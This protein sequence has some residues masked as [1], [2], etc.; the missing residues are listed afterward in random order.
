MNAIEQEVTELLRAKATGAPVRIEPPAEVLRHTRVR[1]VRNAIG[2]TAIAAGLVAGAIFGV[3]SIVGRQTIEPTAPIPWVDRPAVTGAGSPS[4]RSS[5]VTLR[6]G[7]SPT[8]YMRFVASTAATA[9]SIDLFGGGATMR[10][11]DAGGRDMNVQILMSSLTALG[12]GGS[13]GEHSV[14]Y[15]WRNYCGPATRSVQVEIA[16]GPGNG[17][18]TSAYDTTTPSCVDRSK[19]STIQLGVAGSFA[20]PDEELPTDPLYKSL[21]FSIVAPRTVPID[22]TLHYRVVVTNPTGADVPLDPCPIYRHG[23][24]NSTNEIGGSFLLNCE[25]TER[26]VPAR[27]RLV[28]QMQLEGFASIGRAE[29]YWGL[30]TLP[31]IMAPFEVV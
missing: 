26:F 13:V 12:V 6:V 4:C 14:T 20:Y 5:D 22:G 24:H 1:R 31:L 18:L 7:A 21:N 10:L 9:C 28:F 11:L 19:P 27:G 3:Q 8:R 15:E 16:L 17:T 29:L 2:G 30:Q 23:L 25:A